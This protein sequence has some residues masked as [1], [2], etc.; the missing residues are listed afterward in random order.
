MFLILP[1]DLL[2]YTR[3]HSAP[4][5]SVRFISAIFLNLHLLI[6]LYYSNAVVVE[7]PM[8]A[9]YADEKIK[10]FDI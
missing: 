6:E 4:L 2:L 9:Q 7:V 8:K 10:S 5:I 1:M 3:I